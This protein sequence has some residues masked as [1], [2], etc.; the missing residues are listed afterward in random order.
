VSA[1]PETLLERDR[2]VGGAPIGSRR[3]PRLRDRLRGPLPGLLFAA[4]LVLVGGLTGWALA[5][6]TP[7][8]VGA[9]AGLLMALVALRA[10]WPLTLFALMFSPL[11]TM[12]VVKTVSVD[13]RFTLMSWW[14]PAF[15]V[16]A[17][18]LSGVRKIVISKGTW[19]LIAYAIYLNMTALWATRPTDSVREGF[20]FFTFVWVF[21]VLDNIVRTPRQLEIA[22]LAFLTGITFLVGGSAVSGLATPLLPSIRVSGGAAFSFV[23]EYYH[24]V[25]V[26]ASAGS[27]LLITSALLL[28][29]RLSTARRVGLWVALIIAVAFHAVIWKRLES[30]GILMGGF[31]VYSLYGWRRSALYV[32]AGCLVVVT[33]LLAFP[34]ITEHFERATNVESNPWHYALPIAGFILWKQNPILGHGIGSFSYLGAPILARMHILGVHISAEETK[35]PHNLV[36]KIASESGL[37][38]LVLFSIFAGTV[39]WGAWQGAKM[40]KV[41]LPNVQAICR[42][43]LGASIVQLLVSLGENVDNAAIFWIILALGYRAA[44]MLDEA[45]AAAVGAPELPRA[46]RAWLDDPRRASR[47]PV[48]V[49]G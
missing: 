12:I 27:I 4:A 26:A 17:M 1:P 3:W 30:V 23:K 13:F 22:T 45:E 42:G 41:R 38:G 28:G 21:V 9:V 49:P 20:Q 29:A 40:R 16:F 33:V 25:T 7:V 37:V 15:A 18:W 5:A 39:L 46:R 32:I 36:A 34:G 14:L 35:A 24:P 6:E 2:S 47:P 8:V 19:A 48:T 44:R 11:G 31:L 43:M 10:P